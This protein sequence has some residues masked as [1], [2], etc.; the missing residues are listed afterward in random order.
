MSRKEVTLGIDIG[1]TAVKAVVAD[2]HG[3][4]I[5]RTRIPHQLRV[6]A[7]DRLEH[8]ADEAWRRGPLTA[9]GELAG[10]NPRAA[11]VS[12]MVPSLTAVDSTGR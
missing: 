10:E 2:E 5:A 1:S 4:V 12:A 9:L 3:H 6:A 11:A 7:P 8:D